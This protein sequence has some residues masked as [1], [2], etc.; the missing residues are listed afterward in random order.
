MSVAFWS[1]ELKVGK[2]VTVS[3]PEG[4]VLNVQQAAVAG[5]GKTALVVKVLPGFQNHLRIKFIRD[6]LDIN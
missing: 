6:R 1:V 5:E 3:I 4:F 2:P